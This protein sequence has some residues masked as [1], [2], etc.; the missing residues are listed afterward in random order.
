MRRKING[1]IFQESLGTANRKMA[2]KQLA[3]RTE[4]L[5]APTSSPINCAPTP[6]T[7]EEVCEKFLAGNAG[8]KPGTIKNYLWV[9]K[10]L[11]ASFAKFRAPINSIVASDLKLY[12]GSLKH[13]KPRSHNDAALIVGQIFESAVADQYIPRNTLRAVPKLRRRVP[14]SKDRIPTFEEFEGLIADIRSKQFADTR[15][16]SADFI[17]FYGRA[18]VGEAE[19]SQLDWSHVDCVVSPQQLDKRDG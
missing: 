7:L 8:N 9:I 5:K 19:A 14:K 2:E 1:T 16:V 18:A 13:L 6:P 10:G 15:E 3:V 4:E 11:K 17:N 12:F